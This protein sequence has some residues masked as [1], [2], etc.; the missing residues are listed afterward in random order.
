MRTATTTTTHLVYGFLENTFLLNSSI[1][2]C[3]MN[4]ETSV[5]MERE[6]RERES[7]KLQESN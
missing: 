4:V 6:K 2:C 1:T 5:G 3:A 7:S